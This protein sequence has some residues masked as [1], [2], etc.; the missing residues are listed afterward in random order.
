MKIE[1]VI[2]LKNKCNTD[3]RGSLTAIEGGYDIPFDIKRA[4]YIHNVVEDR[5]GHTHLET[6]QF[7]I[8][9]H[10]KLKI[11]VSDGHESKVFIL[12]S[13]EHGVYLP[14]MTWTRLMDFS[15]DAV[16][17]VLSSTHYDMDK[18]IRK[19]ND[20]LAFRNIAERP[21]FNTGPESVKN[22]KEASDKLVLLAQDELLLS[23][24]SAKGVNSIEETHSWIQ[25]RRKSYRYTI[26]KVP[27]DKLTGWNIDAETG[28]ISHCSGKFFKVQGLEI[29]TN[30]GD[31]DHW[32]QPIINQPEIGILG[33]I[34]KKIN[35]TLHLLVQAKMEPGNIDL[36]Q[37]SPTVQATRSNYTQV[38]G[39]KRPAFVEYFLGEKDV[40][41]LY[42]QLQSEQ[43]SN[44][45]KKRNRNVIVKVPDDFEI[46]HSDDFTWLTIGQL[47][48]LMEYSNIVHFD[49]RSILGGLSYVPSVSIK[50][51]HSF[52]AK[53]TFG[54]RVLESIAAEDTRAEIS[55]TKILSIL[56]YHKCHYDIIS[57]PADLNKL[58]DWEYRDG[59]IRHETDSFF[60]ILGISVQAENREVTSWSQPII[61][62]VDGG[63]IA[64]ICQMRNGIL[65]FMVQIRMEA[66]FIDTAEI[67][68]SVQCTPVNYHKGVNKN[69]PPFTELVMNASSGTIRFD[70]M[71]SEEG[72]RFYQSQQRHVIIEMD[73]DFDPALPEKYIWMTLNQIQNCARF[74]NLVNIELRSILA[75]ISP[76]DNE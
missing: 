32:F 51:F 44:Y 6:D 62:S 1:D 25:E 52:N 71:L 18:S 33:F 8:A 14:R 53:H 74:N 3:K 10:G 66:G 69:L 45:L 22:Y 75:C 64:L 17:L 55:L 60:S 30:F 34:A 36:V 50:N 28:S 46:L 43:G 21:E 27:L 38:H 70:S 59:V 56:N 47:Q 31:I 29:S 2:L 73:S 5:G 57:T 48:K 9:V 13:A 26:K 4:F 58:P 15:E 42:D 54:R 35:G 12:D 23:A 67:A 61:H 19:W 40:E 24:L 7:A 65:H 39:G 76:A 68:S 20:Y 49:C 11:L 63:I 16:C 37:I 72:G 41:I